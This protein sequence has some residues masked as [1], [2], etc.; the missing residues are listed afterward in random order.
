MVA[1]KAAEV[2]P[3]EAIP[4]PNEFAGVDI[5]EKVKVEECVYKHMG[6]TS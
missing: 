1:L 3:R 4:S 5:G 2:L 6:D